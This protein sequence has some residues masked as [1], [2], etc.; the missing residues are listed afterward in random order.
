MHGQFPTTLGCSSAV[1]DGSNAYVFGGHNCFGCGVISS[2]FRYDPNAD[3]LTTM[4]STLSTG[5]EAA[6]VWTGQYAYI[7]GGWNGAHANTITRYDTRADQLA[8]VGTLP[9]AVADLAAVWDGKHAFIFGGELPSGVSQSVLRFDPPSG[10]L[11]DTGTQLP[12][13]LFG[14]SAAYDGTTAYVFGGK[15]ANR[16]GHAEIVAYTPIISSCDTRLDVDHFADG[17]WSRTDTSSTVGTG[18]ALITPD[19]NVN[20]GFTL[21]CVAPLDVTVTSRLTSGGNNYVSPKIDIMMS[22]GMDVHAV[23]LPDG[24]YGWYFAACPGSCD[25]FPQGW[26]N[27]GVSSVTAG[28]PLTMRIVATA[29]NILLL[30]Q[31]SPTGPFN[32]SSSWPYNPGGALVRSISISQPWDAGIDVSSI[33]APPLNSASSLAALIQQV[34]SKTIAGLSGTFSGA[35][36]NDGN[37]TRAQV[38]TGTAQVLSATSN[39]STQLDATAAAT[40]AAISANTTSQL[41]LLWQHLDDTAAAIGNAVSNGFTDL[42]GA[43]ASLSG[44]VTSRFNHVDSEVSDGF[45]TTNAKLDGISAS[46]GS[47]MSSEPLNV[48]LNS[49]SDESGTSAIAILV[50]FRGDP[51]DAVLVARINGT[52]QNAT[53]VR[54]SNGTFAY[55]PPNA[56]P[57]DGPRLLEIQATA[58]GHHGVAIAWL[59]TPLARTQ[60]ATSLVGGTLTS[61]TEFA[62][63][64]KTNATTQANDTLARLESPAPTSN[65][66]YH[67]L[68]N[69]SQTFGPVNVSTPGVG[70]TLV[71][72]GE[73]RSGFYVLTTTVL[74]NGSPVL[75]EPIP[76]PPPLS[77]PPIN[78]S[79]GQVDPV[80][81]QNGTT[82]NAAL[83]IGYSQDAN[84]STCVGNGTCVPVDSTHPSWFVTNGGNSTLVVT[85]TLTPNSGNQVS[86]PL[87]IPLAGQFVGAAGQ[88]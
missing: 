13:P 70:P 67:E 63:A 86:I 61:A 15:D 77:L 10:S 58:D 73:S 8:T 84:A 3:S 80:R 1:W 4:T 41:A 31:T 16:A 36:T 62:N 57:T 78:E 14:H 88:R 26:N 45:N 37:A 49:P 55:S 66:T 25:N 51:T 35:V 64:T 50:S 59:R 30:S 9:Y 68:A 34:P 54:F 24:T 82:L 74:V 12:N 42:R 83:V 19:G 43:V 72:T 60:P 5:N 23:S 81:I 20:S 46:L 11:I 6:A 65:L 76:L 48:E 7:F 71:V 17:S 18:H 52:T 28:Q 87:V 56:Q 33:S 44:L 85:L 27:S 39:L 53:F 75:S 32:I 47:T 38:T 22:D 2:I 40:Q 29:T 21:P 69:K 79:F